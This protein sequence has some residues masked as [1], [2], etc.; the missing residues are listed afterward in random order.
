MIKMKNTNPATKIEDKDMLFLLHLSQLF[1]LITGFGGLI[2]PILIWVFKK[3]EIQG[4]NEQG[5]EVI[6][7]QITMFL[8]ILVSIPLCFILIGFLFISIIAL[9]MI[10]VPIIQAI[11]SK[12]NQ[13]V[14]YPLTIRFI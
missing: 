12:D 5:K 4:I 14:R 13:S 8:A 2:A 3:D 1:N 10:I 11:K 6:N 7:F 9:L